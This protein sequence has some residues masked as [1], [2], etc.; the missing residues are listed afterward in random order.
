MATRVGKVETIQGS[1]ATSQSGTYRAN[2]VISANSSATYLIVFPK[3]FIKIPT[4]ISVSGSYK[5]IDGKTYASG[6]GMT[7]SIQSKTAGGF[8]CIAKN[9]NGGQN[10]D[11]VIN[12]SAS[13]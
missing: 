12:W 11:I 6:N 5:Y 10:S 13:V 9:T 7:L 8:T 1:Y 2:G 4:N 3:S